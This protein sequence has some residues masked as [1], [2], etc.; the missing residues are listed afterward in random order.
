MFIP[1]KIDDYR[2][3]P[4]PNWRSIESTASTNESKKWCTKP[5]PEHVLAVPSGSPINCKYTYVI[6]CHHISSYL[7]CHTI[8]VALSLSQRIHG[9]G[10]FTNPLT[11]RVIKNNPNVGK[12]SIH[13]SLGYPYP[14][15]GS[16][17]KHQPCSPCR[18]WE[19]QSWGAQIW[20]YGG[21]CTQDVIII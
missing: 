11:P 12:Y 21:R 2:Y 1:L 4:I 3:W 13:G 16:T 20:D 7:T 5:W 19:L 15:L 18:R 10:I 6:N 17:E 8:I 14:S 9:A